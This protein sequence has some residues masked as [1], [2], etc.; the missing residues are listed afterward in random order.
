MKPDAVTR[1]ALALVLGGALQLVWL[2]VGFASKSE[3][4]PASF[5][6]VL[7]SLVFILG[8]SYLARLRGLSGW[9][10]LSGI[11]SVLGVLVLWSIPT[12]PESGSS[13]H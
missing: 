11:A 10:G 7:G 9:Y 5:L 1:T 13:A 12:E 8:C 6:L 4:N 3:V 2:I